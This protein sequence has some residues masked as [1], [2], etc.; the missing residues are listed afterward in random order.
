MK[1]VK[2]I[3]KRKKV[4][5]LFCG[6]GGLTHGFV[7]EKFNVV[8]GYDIDSTCK[9]PYETNNNAKFFRS[10]ISE[11]EAT[12]I[13]SHYEDED[14]K[15]LVGCAPCQPFS[16]YAY[17]SSDKE[18]WKLLSHF[19]RLINEVQPD[20]ISM[21]N[22]PRLVNYSKAP[23][24]QDFVDSLEINGYRVFYEIVNCPEYGLPQNRKRLVL[25]ASKF[26]EIKLIPKTHKNKDKY[27]TVKDAI[28]KLE[29]L[30]SGETS[31]KDPLHKAAKLSDL[32]LKRI[33]QSKP[34]GTWRDWDEEL[35]LACHKKKTGKTYVSVYGRM[36]WDK[37][38]PTMTTFCTGIGNG[39]FGHP[40]QD[41]AISLR[42]AALLQ[43]FPQK[44]KFIE[45]G[46]SLSMTTL[47][48][49]IGN[50]VPVRLG[51]VIAKSINKHLDKYYD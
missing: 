24:F 16:T 39:R 29:P 34:G 12:D 27:K 20:I 4:V 8:A 35:Q 33:Q 9:Y 10:D 36:E 22:V 14:V 48:T 25:L 41:R 11:L 44:Y 23:V 31:K 18:K 45:K 19:S 26:G 5:D 3:S 15:I 21:E 1:S 49:H 13:L 28:G 40:E 43:T 17:K 6:I 51:Q 50:A 7:K 46:E 38:S 32:N 47:S 2:G 37:P 30:E 42:E